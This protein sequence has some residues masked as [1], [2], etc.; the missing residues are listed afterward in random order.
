MNLSSQFS[1]HH[2]LSSQTRETDLGLYIH[3]P[4]CRKRCHFCA[5]YLQIHQEHLVQN[6][7][8]ALEDEIHL[9]AD[10]SKLSI[11]PVT[12]VYFGGGTPTSLRAGQLSKVLAIIRE[13]FNLQNEA[14]ITVEASPDTVTQD[15]LTRLCESGVNRISFGAQ[16]FD[17]SEW[18]RLGRLGMVD[19]VFYAVHLARLAGFINI[20][21]DLMYGLPG[22]TLGSWGKSLHQALKLK[23]THVSC[24]A[25]TIE[26]GT[27]FHVDR[28]RGDLEEE[29]PQVENDMMDLAVSCLNERGYRRYEISNFCQNGYECRH[30]LRHWKGYDYVGFGPS[31]QSY[32]SGVRFGNVED[33]NR[34]VRS[35]SNKDFP[36]GD[37]EFLTESQIDRE[38]VIFGLRLLSGLELSMMGELTQEVS[39]NLSVDRLI[40]QGML[41]EE[42]NCLHLTEMGRRFVDTAAVELM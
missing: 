14:E 36:L 13:R 40:Q 4:F 33:L 11:R 12:T 30:N 31:A 42:A 20:N 1:L 5:F 41:I 27:R 23:P 39:W 18:E 24:Y 16:S 37:V 35:L 10:I 3:I 8:T 2:R 25:L 32:G 7:L 26:E 21:L 22:Q 19:T 28:H 9:Y 34:Y 38:R 29:D 15:Y 17:G 6:F